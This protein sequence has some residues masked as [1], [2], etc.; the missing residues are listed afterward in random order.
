M[1]QDLIEMQDSSES[2]D[3]ENGQDDVVTEIVDVDELKT[4][5]QNGEERK[6][7]PNPGSPVNED[8]DEKNDDFHHAKNSIVRTSVL[9]S[10]TPNVSFCTLRLT[11]CPKNNGLSLKFK[12]FPKYTLF[13][14]T[15]CFCIQ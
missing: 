2:A 14:E 11:V 12:V 10:S 13:V 15:N 4:E 8:S 1:E 3:F 7:S 9:P 5:P 6:Q